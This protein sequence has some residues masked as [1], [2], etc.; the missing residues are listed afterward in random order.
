MNFALC[1]EQQ[2][3]QKQSS[4]DQILMNEPI[5]SGENAVL[6]RPLLHAYTA[7]VRF[8]NYVPTVTYV[9]E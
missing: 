7:S 5:G 1:K 8:G 3:S 9:I 2:H 4:R 6:T